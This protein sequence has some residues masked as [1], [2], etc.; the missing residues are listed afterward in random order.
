MK[1]YLFTW[2]GITDLRA[3]LGFEK[4]GGPVLGAIK[5]KEYTDVAILGYTDPNKPEPS[6]KDKNREDYWRAYSNTDSAHTTFA[7]WLNTQI[8]SESLNVNFNLYKIKLKKLND[9][10][11]IYKAVS[12]VLDTISSKNEIEDITF[13][14]S[15]GTPVMAF[16]W[17]LTSLSNP[18][19]KIKVIASSVPNNPPEL[20]SLPSELMKTGL[21]KKIRKTDHNNF[22]VIFHLFGEQRLPM[23]FAINHFQ[24]EKHIFHV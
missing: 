4:S 2:Y 20:I 11:G 1:K 16:V 5:T 3:T 23:I 9:T 14:L 22:D 18:S 17:A 15:P 24:T 12:K 13:F 6:S 10:D 8:E 19:L 7:K 21:P